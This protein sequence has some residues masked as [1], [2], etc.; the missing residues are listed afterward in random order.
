M[1]KLTLTQSSKAHLMRTWGEDWQESQLPKRSSS[2]SRMF[3]VLA[4]LFGAAYYLS[5][6]GGG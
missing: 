5:S 2:I 6:G 4:S 3:F 1:P